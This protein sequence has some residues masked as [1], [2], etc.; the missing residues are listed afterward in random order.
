M[1][2]RIPPLLIAK[3][4]TA[5]EQRKLYERAKKKAVVKL[6][7]GIYVDKE[8]WWPLWSSERAYTRAIAVG[9]TQPKGILCGRAAARVLGLALEFSD[10]HQ[11]ID[12]GRFPG[13]NSYVA[14]GVRTRRIPEVAVQTA[15]RI[16]VRVPVALE[17]YGA[18]GVGHIV[19]KIGGKGDTPSTT[20]T[21]A[22]HT[23]RTATAKTTFTL[24]VAHPA[25]T[26]FT[27]AAW[28]SMEDAVVAAEEALRTGRLTISTFRRAAPHF[29]NLAHSATFRQACR[30]INSHSESPRESGLKCKFFREGLPAPLQQP[31]VFDSGHNPIGRP[32]FLFDGTAGLIV[33]YDGDGKYGTPDNPEKAFRAYQNERNR[34]KRPLGVGLR[35]HRVYADTYDDPEMMPELLQA[36]NQQNSLRAGAVIPSHLIQGGYRAWV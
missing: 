23:T 5:G 33:E 10:R 29:T 9:A 20:R 18:S 15:Q 8:L 28:H 6:A 32:D 4:L 19:G 31:T 27:L 34:E 3:L 14:Q 1:G 25:Y 13:A 16:I 2:R 35:M 22:S 21:A 26:V 36:F 30:L 11:P 7:P 17:A 24:T 12:V